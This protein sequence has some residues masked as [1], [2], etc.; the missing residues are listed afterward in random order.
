MELS[1]LMVTWLYQ[2]TNQYNRIAWISMLR[3]EFKVA[4]VVFNLQ[5]TN[6][7]IRENPTT[8]P[9]EP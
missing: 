1:Q 3:G 2:L 4:V 6:I 9:E 8:L 7:K 5:K